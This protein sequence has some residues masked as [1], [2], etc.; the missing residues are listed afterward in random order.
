MIQEILNFLA[1]SP[2]F[3]VGTAGADGFPR[4]RPFSFA[5]EW[6]GKLTFATARPKKVHAQLEENPRM[7]I[8]SFSPAGEWMRISGEIEFTDERS[9]REK[10]FEVM[11][12]LLQI[13]PEGADDPTVAVFYIKP[14][15]GVADTYDF[16]AVEPIRT[17]K[18]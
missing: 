10:E 7:E 2:A 1:Q 4:V 13:Y 12:R 6:D 15:T 16:T 8:C 14:G 11:P 5:M 9:A 3:Y 17:V 18:F